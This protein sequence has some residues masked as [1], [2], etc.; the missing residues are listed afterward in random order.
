MCV[1]LGGCIAEDPWKCSVE[2]EVVWRKLQAAIL[3]VKQFAHSKQAHFEQALQL[4]KRI[5][6]RMESSSN[7]ISPFADPGE[8]MM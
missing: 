1:T 4:K 6:S 3:E 2:C 5:R 7:M 8:I